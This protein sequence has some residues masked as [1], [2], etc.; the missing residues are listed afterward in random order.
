MTRVLVTGMS[1]AGKTRLLDELARRGVTTVD[2]D[3]GGWTL[4]DGTWDEPRMTAL[5]AGPGD[6]AVSGTAENQGRFYD[7]F[8]EVVLLSAPLEVLLERVA[9]RT[10]N[11][12][13]RTA[14]QRAEI[15]RW[16][17]EV[18]PL[19]RPGATL[20]LDGRRAVEDLADVVERLLTAG[21]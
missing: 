6:V 20:E 3:Y 14:A 12:Y 18:E 7:R 19:L 10:N 11:P 8:D 5:L 17:A 21:A 4:P 9:R 1:G 13:G 15:R 2:T 16:V